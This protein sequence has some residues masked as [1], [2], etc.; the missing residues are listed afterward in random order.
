MRGFTDGRWFAPVASSVLNPLGTPTHR[1]PRGEV[2][3]LVE[4]SVPGIDI[5]TLTARGMDV[6]SFPEEQMRVN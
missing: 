1:H 5:N 6:S 4:E 3:T 2:L